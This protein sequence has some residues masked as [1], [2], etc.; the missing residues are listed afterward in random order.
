M[1]KREKKKECIIAEP[2][3]AA[4]LAKRKVTY[5]EEGKGKGKSPQNTTNHRKRA[6]NKPLHH[7]D[8]KIHKILR[9]FV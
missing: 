3:A 6:E 4:R 1:K 2:E 9:N 8:V 7:F 5:N